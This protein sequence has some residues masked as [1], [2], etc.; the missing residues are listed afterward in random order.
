MVWQQNGAEM[1]T[2]IALKIS[3][4]IIAM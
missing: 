2:A 4:R 1:V 3:M